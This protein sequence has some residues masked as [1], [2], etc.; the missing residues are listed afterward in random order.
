MQLSF[1]KTI[2]SLLSKTESCYQLLQGENYMNALEILQEIEREYKS[3]QLSI[4]LDSKTEIIVLL[5]SLNCYQIVYYYK[6]NSV[7]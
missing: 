1:V 4:V 2:Q 7:Y 5:I 3:S 6:A